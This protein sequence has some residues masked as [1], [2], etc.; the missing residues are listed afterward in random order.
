MHRIPHCK[1]LWSS[2]ECQEDQ[3]WETLHWSALSGSVPS[4]IW[5]R[6]RKQWREQCRK[7]GKGETSGQG[8]RGGSRSS[9]HPT[10]ELFF[11]GT[12]ELVDSYPRRS[13]AA[14]GLPLVQLSVWKQSELWIQLEGYAPRYRF[15]GVKVPREPGRGKEGKIPGVECWQGLLH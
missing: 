8:R 7:L 2:S 4:E 3:D 12:R 1:E 10:S 13:V 9:V 15:W 5:E 6:R 11:S 14:H